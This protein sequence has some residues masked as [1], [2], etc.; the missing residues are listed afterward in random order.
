MGDLG[1][2]GDRRLAIRAASALGLAMLARRWDVHDAGARYDPKRYRKCKKQAKKR[3]A[4]LPVPGGCLA[5]KKER[6]AR[7][8]L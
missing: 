7:K 6:C 8:Y 5:A 1:H 2:V 3:C 4:G